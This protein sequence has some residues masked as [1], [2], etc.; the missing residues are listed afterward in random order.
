MSENVYDF[1]SN[2]RSSKYLTNF[3]YVGSFR[4]VGDII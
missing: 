2:P 4:I 1:L 3:Y